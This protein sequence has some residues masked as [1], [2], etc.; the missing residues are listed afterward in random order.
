LIAVCATISA[1]TTTQAEVTSDAVIVTRGDGGAVYDTLA[2]YDKWAAQGK[3]IIIDG[4]MISSDAFGAFS[5]PNVCYTENAV[6][7]P[8]AA[9]YVG[10]IPHYGATEQLTRMLPVPLQNE[11]RSS[12]HYYNWITTAHFDYEDLL[13]IWAEGACANQ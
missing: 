6:F 9:S 11:F 5:A 8:H 13:R 10:L 2:Q 1:C 4:N 3:K 12:I 7:S